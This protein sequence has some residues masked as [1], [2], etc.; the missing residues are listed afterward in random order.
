V[1]GEVAADD[2]GAG[3]LEALVGG[4]VGVA[5][6]QLPAICFQ[7]VTDKAGGG[8]NPE[9]GALIAQVR[10]LWKAARRPPPAE[11]PTSCLDGKGWDELYQLTDRLVRHLSFEY[12]SRREIEDALI[13]AVR[14]YRRWP[15]GQR[16]EAKMLAADFLDG[17]AREPSRRTVYLGVQHVKL[18]DGV[19]AGS[20]RF[21]RVS[22]HEALAQAFAGFG[23]KA[24]ELVCEVE[25]VG[26][27]DELLLGRARQTAN[28]ALAL[29]RQ[30]MLFG[31]NA[32]IYLDQV[33]FELDGTYTWRVGP[34]MA[35]A[36]WWRKPRP[37][38]MDFTTSN[39]D[40]WLA[41]LAD[42][43]ADYAAVAAGLR[44]RVDTC[45]DWLDVAARSDKWR[46]IVPA[47]FSAMEAILVPESSGL[48]AGIVT[49]RS[50]AVHVAIGGGFFHPH[51]TVAGYELR[52]DLVHGKPT[53]DVLD[54]DA[55]DFADF[56][57]LW[58]FD[59]LRDYL[60][61]AKTID[62]TS[63]SDIID[64]LSNGSCD[65]VCAWLDE[66]DGSAI[67]EEYK[68]SATPTRPGRQPEGS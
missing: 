4:V 63:V 26:G 55:A 46:I 14:R 66:H 37:I 40:A 50:V 17:L 51:K 5:A 30:Q 43:S 58:G 11:A 21:L 52:N 27:T 54:K 16:P 57:R 35:R 2:G 49:V 48:K 34:E 15:P 38:A 53:F 8:D 33:M 6:G 68:S 9:R 3:E 32:K 64:H 1:R 18:P 45:I 29:V 47:V 62:A 24:P 22:Q 67:V 31:F 36:A 42:L 20:A 25:A 41:K 60:K 13:E 59:V 44:E 56:T 10:R 28:S 12:L 7:F 39:A 65:Q 23:D 61:L 19:V